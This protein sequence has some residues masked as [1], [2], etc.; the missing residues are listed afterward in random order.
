MELEFPKSKVSVT[1]HGRLLGRALCLALCYC[2]VSA[3]L[4]QAAPAV[5]HDVID[6]NVGM[7]VNV[8][9]LMN[10]T[11]N[12][13]PF[14]L[15]TLAI[16]SAPAT[17][18][19]DVNAEEGTITYTP[20][21]MYSGWAYFTYTIY[22][23]AG[24]GG[25]NVTVAEVAVYVV[26]P[27][28]PV[29]FEDY[30]YVEYYETPSISVLNNDVPNEAPIDQTTLTLRSLPRHGTVN[31]DPQDPTAFVYIPDPGF[32]GEDSFYY[33]FM[34]TNGV[35]SNFGEVLLHVDP[36]DPPVILDLKV[37]WV[38]PGVW[39]FEGHAW[40]ELRES[41]VIH[42]TGVFDATYDYVEPDT[43]K[44]L[45]VKNLGGDTGGLTVFAR[46]QEGVDSDPVYDIVQ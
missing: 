40:D 44:Y 24:V 4:T 30:V 37:I 5:K 3:S 18:Q 34:D 13:D 31:P 36:N 16:H 12:P 9:V 26:P 8:F 42:F 2:F 21:P 20:A 6:T 17:G 11:S 1:K 15:S 28:A 33:Q 29:A 35:Y 39:S 25:A 7:P 41:L 45:V 38:S 23:T 19:A 22:D 32:S 43:G 27:D 10:D 14:D 46:D